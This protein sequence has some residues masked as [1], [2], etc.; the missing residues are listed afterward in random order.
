MG[1]F[2]QR[3]KQK[4][5]NRT[6]LGIHVPFGA[7]ITGWNNR[8]KVARRALKGVEDGNGSPGLAFGMVSGQ[9]GGATPEEIVARRSRRTRRC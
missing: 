3:F 4:V 9:R 1:G 5:R 6:A 8:K 2:L 7:K